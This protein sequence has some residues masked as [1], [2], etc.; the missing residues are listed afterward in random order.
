MLSDSGWNTRSRYSMWGS[1]EERR[2]LIRCKRAYAMIQLVFV[3]AWLTKTLSEGVKEDHSAE[4]FSHSNDAAIRARESLAE[5]SLEQL[6]N[7]LKEGG[8]VGIHGQITPVWEGYLL[9]GYSQMPPTRIA[10]GGRRS[11]PVYPVSRTSN[12]CFWSR[13]VMIPR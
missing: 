12:S 5:E 10:L 4:Y 3:M 9:N 8:N 11:R 13:S 6:I 7:W 1:S 2:R